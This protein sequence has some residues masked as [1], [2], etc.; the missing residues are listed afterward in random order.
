MDGVYCVLLLRVIIINP[1]CAVLKRLTLPKWFMFRLT[2]TPI[3]KLLLT[4]GFVLS[5]GIDIILISHIP[6]LL[7]TVPRLNKHR[8]S[9]ADSEVTRYL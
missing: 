8:P 4:V 1:S 3:P 2:N 7:C 5:L 9:L 6:S